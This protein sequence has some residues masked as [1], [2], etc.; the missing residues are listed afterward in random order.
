VD[1]TAA[2][3]RWRKQNAPAIAAARA[4]AAEEHVKIVMRTG[5]SIGRQ[6]FALAAEAAPK[7]AKR[8]TI[9]G[10]WLSN[11]G[12]QALVQLAANGRIN[13]N[14]SDL[15]TFM[16]AVRIGVNDEMADRKMTLIEE[17]KA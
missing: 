6:L 3:A 17:A 12:T 5:Y 15:S 7:D 4:K 1:E 16:V 14:M 9:C 10:R 13:I 11:A 8:F 2:K